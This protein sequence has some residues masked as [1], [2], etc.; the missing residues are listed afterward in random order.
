VEFDGFLPHEYEY[1]EEAQ[2]GLEEKRNSETSFPAGLMCFTGMERLN[3]DIFDTD[4]KSMDTYTKEAIA[5]GE[6]MNKWLQA[7][8]EKFVGGKIPSIFVW[9]KLGD[10]YIQVTSSEVEQGQIHA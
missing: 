1:F 4:F 10:G 8:K 3:I 5:I 9:P 2:A 7:R 6:A